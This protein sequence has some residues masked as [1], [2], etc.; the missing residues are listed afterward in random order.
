MKN[1]L[2]NIIGIDEAG[3]GPLAGP[4]AVGG[5]KI[6]VK[7]KAK[8]E[9]LREIFFGIKDSK[10]LTEKQREKWFLFLTAH[11]D[12]ECAVAF[13]SP[14]VID[15]INIRNA[16][17][18]GARR[19]YAKLSLECPKLSLGQHARGAAAPR[20]SVMLDGGLFLPESIC[21]NQK[22]IIKGDE[23]IP[24]IAAASIIAKVSRDRLM[25]HLHKKYP[26]YRF[27]LHKGYSTA[28][29]R[30]M[31]KKFGRCEIHRRSFRILI[32]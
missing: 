18:L 22:T 4:V 17:L 30:E 29:H 32:S 14:A 12:F 9:K 13:V 1:F 15:R 20:A 27:D 2:Q 16:A 11:P 31:I 10:Q 24:L 21:A 19:V 28:L 3:R 5:V 8:S 23:K 6:N 26:Q 25:R 7:R